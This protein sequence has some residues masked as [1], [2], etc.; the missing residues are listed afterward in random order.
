MKV[1]HAL[2]FAAFAIST[3]SCATIRVTATDSEVSEKNSSSL[4]IASLASSAA[5]DVEIP[6][7]AE[8][9]DQEIDSP[10]SDS[11]QT[12]SASNLDDETSMGSEDDLGPTGNSGGAIPPR[13]GP[14]LP[15]SSDATSHVKTTMGSVAV[16]VVAVCAYFL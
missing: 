15:G 4:P 5:F 16:T 9:P 2:L 10:A 13:V 7:D 11:S 1:F 12:S 14:M 6:S 8:D 3:V